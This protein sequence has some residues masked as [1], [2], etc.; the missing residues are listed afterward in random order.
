MRILLL[1]TWFPYPPD[2]GSRIRAYNLLKH[3]AA[4]HAVHLVSFTRDHEADGRGEIRAM[5]ASVE[6]V[7]WIEFVPTRWRALLGY[8]S[9]APRS[10]VDTYSR[11]MDRH[12]KCRLLENSFG[13]V[14][15]LQS[16]A[17]RYVPP[18]LTVPALLDEIEIGV[19]RDAAVRE[20]RWLAY[21][22]AQ[23]RYAKLKRYLG[24][25]L[26]RF[27]VCTVV[28]Q[29]EAQWLREAVPHYDSV[30]VV[31]NGVDTDH[32]RPSDNA[33]QP[34]T[35]IYSGALTYSANYDA[36]AYFLGDIMP[37]I[38]AEVPEVQFR[39]TGSTRGVALERLPRR[40]GVVFTGYVEDIRPVVAGSWAL[41]VPL[42]VGGGTRLKILEAMALG[43]PVISTTKGAEGLDVRHEENILIADSPHDFAAQ[44]V[45][46]LRDPALRRRLAENGR[47]LV[48]QKYSWAEI[49]RQF[50][51]LVEQVA[52][53]GRR[54]IC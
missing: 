12:V 7:P 33:P 27:R 54:H 20:T 9:V 29:P 39:V 49:G 3:V 6:T 17:A 36:V 1:S 24:N 30:Y 38:Q 11:T 35:L 4:R 52:D 25:L 31:P 5:C 51:H 43:T 10:V 48:E 26:G 46:L 37:R 50:C 32:Y 34:D 2:N 23:L 41:V 14:V 28:S 19:L 21:I 8:F 45:R 40:P 44:T 13:I 42:R 16:P 15:A 53:T 47:R 18:R 22:R